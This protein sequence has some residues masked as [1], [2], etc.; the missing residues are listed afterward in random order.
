MKW[1]VTGNNGPSYPYLASEET[2]KGSDGKDYPKWEVHASA[3]NSC[4]IN[5]MQDNY[6][7]RGGGWRGQEV[8]PP[9]PTVIA[10]QDFISGKL[11]EAL[12]GSLLET[13]K[14]YRATL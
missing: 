14:A 6:D 1:I 2:I 13:L 12:G 11:L 4:H 10:R 5:Q 7:R 3:D 8:I 9:P